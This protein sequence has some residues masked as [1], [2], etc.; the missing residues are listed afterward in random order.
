MHFF[1]FSSFTFL[2]DKTSALALTALAQPAGV[3]FHE[4]GSEVFS[5]ELYLCN[6]DIVFFEQVTYTYDVRGVN[7]KNI[8]TAQG[9]ETWKGTGVSLLTGEIY[10]L[11]DAGRFNAKESLT[12]GVAVFRNK[13]DGVLTGNEGSM[14]NFVGKSHITVNANGDVTADHGSL[15]SECQ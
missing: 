6:G 7:N 4:Q 15:T 3:S 5:E 13:V 14:D 12:N 11:D 1:S 10:T 8:S 2:K 9:T